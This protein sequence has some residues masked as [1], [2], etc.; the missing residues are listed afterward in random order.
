M[1]R[2]V[3]PNV[4]LS[5]SRLSVER[6]GASWWPSCCSKSFSTLKIELWQFKLSPALLAEMLFIFFPFVFLFFSA[7]LEGDHMARVSICCTA[8]NTDQPGPARSAGGSWFKKTH[9]KPEEV[10][11][12]GN[13]CAPNKNAL[14]WFGRTS[15]RKRELENV[16]SQTSYACPIKAM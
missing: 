8:V 12:S 6:F 15:E 14:H 16:M 2:L 10:M 4:L 1:N 9:P 5:L 7:V 3:Y 13:L 11:R